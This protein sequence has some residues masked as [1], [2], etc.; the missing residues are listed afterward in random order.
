MVT[1]PILTVLRYVFISAWEIVEDIDYDITGG[2]DGGYR[3]YTFKNNVKEGLWKVEVI[4]NEELVLG[5]VDFKVVMGP[6]LSPKGLISR[7]F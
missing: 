1:L 4:T 5:V 2:R 7:R 6:S 3:G